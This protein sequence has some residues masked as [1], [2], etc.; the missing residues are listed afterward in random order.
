MP[1]RIAY[2][3]IRQATPTPSLPKPSCTRTN[4]SK[5]S[6]LSQALSLQ[7]EG[8]SVTPFKRVWQL[9]D[10]HLKIKYEICNQKLTMKASVDIVI[11]STFA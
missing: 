2:Q 1:K 6:C 8:A 5:L 3:L 11:F 4:E 10:I 7:K 9:A